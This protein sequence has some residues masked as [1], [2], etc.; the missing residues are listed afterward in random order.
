VTVIIIIIIIIIL[1]IIIK[2]HNIL[3]VER[4]ELSF[5][6]LSSKTDYIILS[7]QY[8]EIIELEL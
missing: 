5:S 8:I 6:C 1:I 3:Q 2:S 4:C 7:I